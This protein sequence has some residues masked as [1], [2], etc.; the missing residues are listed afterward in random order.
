MDELLANLNTDTS[1]FDPPSA[2]GAAFDMDNVNGFITDP[3]DVSLYSDIQLRTSAPQ[4]T[5]ASTHSVQPTEMDYLSDPT[6]PQIN[7]K[8]KIDADPQ[9]PSLPP[10]NATNN[11][12]SKPPIR[13]DPLVPDT[14]DTPLEAERRRLAPLAASVL[15]ECW[16][17]NKIPSDFVAAVRTRLPVRGQGLAASIVE[18]SNG[19]AAPKKST[20]MDDSS[21]MEWRL[22]E[23]SEG[24]LLDALFMKLVKASAISSRLMTYLEYSLVTGIVSQRAVIS[25][26]LKWIATPQISDKVL[27]SFAQ[28]M[29]QIIPHYRFTASKGTEEAEMKEF[30]GAFVMVIE[31]VA[32][33]PSLAP[34]LVEVLTHDRV[35]ALVRACARRM[36]SMWKDIDAAIAGLETPGDT[37]EANDPDRHTFVPRVAYIVSP[38]LPQLVARL[39]KGLAV[40]I[41]SMKSIVTSMNGIAYPDENATLPTMLQA[42]FGV[43][44]AVFGGEIAQ[45]L[46]Q[47]WSQSE[48]KDYNVLAALEKGARSGTNQQGKSA[49]P[50]YS[51]KNKV[52]ACEAIVRFLGERASVAGVSERWKTHFGGKER[53]KRLI[54]DAVPQVKN[55]I[56][57]ESGALLVAMAVTCCAAMCL[58]PSLRMDDPN[59][60]IDNLD[61]KEVSAQVTQ[62][63]EVEEAMSELVG[64]AVG[65]LQDAALAEEVPAWRSFGLWLLLLMSRAGAMLRA[66]GCEHSKAAGVLRA[67]AGV[68]TGTPGSHTAQ[69]SHKHS[70]QSSSGNH[71]Q[72]SSS[73]GQSEGVTMF[74]TT[75]SLAIIDASDMSGS[76]STIQALCADL[77]Q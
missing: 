16:Q 60:G 44:L 29:M 51:F 46:R 76:Y 24:A 54:R 9:I 11:S 12:R 27:N 77:V 50:I 26:C 61:P 17:T 8:S 41:T 32:R 49:S 5:P 10:L 64:F 28:L 35:I 14:P 34:K 43:T 65:S 68:P 62:N 58:G 74:A 3:Q 56:K 15:T 38:E 19:P 71:H 37:T 4:Q 25:T 45:S 18:T 70:S 21:E 20:D 30:L 33:S 6:E 39:K 63:E 42:S 47:L 55:E 40:G 75:A 67:W 57:S 52:I 1:M 48:D 13:V 59:D 53:L 23:A 22:P 31:C 7:Q 36:P 66:C 73:H 72:S 69:S 2:L